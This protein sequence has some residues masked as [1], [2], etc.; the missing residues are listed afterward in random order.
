MAVSSMGAHSLQGRAFLPASRG[1]SGLESISARG[2]RTLSEQASWLRRMNSPA[3]RSGIV[4]QGQNIPR[5][6]SDRAI[7]KIEGRISN[8]L[9]DGSRLIRNKSGDPVFLSKDCIRRV[10]FDFNNSHGDK[11]HVHFEKK[12]NIRWV[13][14][15]SKHR[16][17]PKDI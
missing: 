5:G 8:W 2:Q 3:Y 9:G 15:S 4:K 14:A 16:I 12:V 6:L 13:D 11:M 17:Y 1:I 7:T 10:R